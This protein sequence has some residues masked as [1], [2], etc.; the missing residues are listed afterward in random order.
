MGTI[1]IIGAMEVEVKEL[2]EQ[3]Q[4]TRQLTKAGMEFCEGILE[5]Q[6]VVVV[7]S[8]V[9]K[10]NAAVCT[11]ILIDV[12]DVKAVI[13]T[14]IAGSLKAEINIGDLV[15]SSDLVHH[16]MDAVSLVIRR[17]DSADGCVLFE[18]DKAL[19]DLAEK[20][21]EEVNPEIQVFHGRVV[22]G[23]QFIADKETKE[24]IST[25]FAGYCTEMEGAAIA[26][27]AHLN[28]VPFVVL[29]AI[30]DKADDSASMDYPTFEK[31]A[32][33]HSVRLVCGMMKNLAAKE[34]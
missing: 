13:N 15:I 26:Q 29:R 27:T 19:A 34:A 30:S 18:A 12:F 4:I 2:K 14:G 5:G 33:A 11:Q 31:Q 6:D 9:G 23:D 28:E 1:G 21:C 20:V 22:S 10:V 16:D 8:G 32:V 24:N 17:T 3:M 7:R 25:L